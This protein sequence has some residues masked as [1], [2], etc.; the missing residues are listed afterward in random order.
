MEFTNFANNVIESGYQ[1]DVVYTDFQ[2]AFDRVNHRILL[3]KLRIQ[4]IHSL[5]LKWIE[6]YLIEREQYVMILNHKLKTFS[7]TS[8]V[9]QSSHLGPLLFILFMYDIPSCFSSARCLI[10]ADDL[11]LFFPVKYISDALTLQSYINVLYS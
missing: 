2:K 4:G 3:N 7:V 1:L 9:P 10:Y 6:S 8:C 11:K 5:A